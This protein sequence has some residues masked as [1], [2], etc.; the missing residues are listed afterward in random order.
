MFLQITSNQGIVKYII[1]HS[2]YWLFSSWV[3][4]HWFG[5]L[6]LKYSDICWI[7]KMNIDREHNPSSSFT[8]VN[9]NRIDSVGFDRN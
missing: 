1:D 5:V 3:I 2:I 4:N 7:S 8:L 9:L 6:F